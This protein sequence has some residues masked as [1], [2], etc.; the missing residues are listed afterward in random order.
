MELITVY[1][2]NRTLFVRI[3]FV[4]TIQY[5]VSDIFVIDQLLS[6][7]SLIIGTNKTRTK[8]ASL[9]YTNLSVSRAVLSS[10]MFG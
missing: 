6:P 7:L 4:R 2:H 10:N 1:I 3:L 9:Y 5:R 8:L